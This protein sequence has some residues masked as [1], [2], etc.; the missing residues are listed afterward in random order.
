[1]QTLPAV[2]LDGPICLIL[3]LVFGYLALHGRVELFVG[4]DLV[5]DQWTRTVFFFGIPH[6]YVMGGF[7]LLAAGISL[8][9]NGGFRLS[10]LRHRWIIPWVLHWWAW[11]LL[12]F[13][14]FRSFGPNFIFFVSNVLLVVPLAL[15]F[16]GDLK[17]VRAFALAYLATT[18]V[19]G[20]LT[21]DF[22]LGTYPFS[23]LLFDPMLSFMPLIHSISSNPHFFAT[24]FVI[25]IMLA[26]MLAEEARSFWK[27]AAFF[28]ATVFCAYILI[29]LGLRQHIVGVTVALAIRN[30][31]HLPSAKKAKKMRVSL[32][33]LATVIISVVLAWQAY[34]S[35]PG[36]FLKSGAGEYTLVDVLYGL[37]GRPAVWK[38]DWETFLASPSWGTGFRHHPHNVF[39]GTLTGQG[40]V[41][42]VY[43]AG[44]LVFAARVALDTSRR[45]IGEE[46]VRW[47][48][49]M[50]LVALVALVTG[51]FSGDTNSL[52]HLFW[53]VVIAWNLQ[54]QSTAVGVDHRELSR[55]SI[56]R[57]ALLAPDTSPTTSTVRGR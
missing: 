17:R 25:S 20:V 45:P 23:Y 29:L 40:I 11:E 34:Q 32:I 55:R 35:M 10:G 9:Q 52:W 18:V 28:C 27:R 1:M 24:P 51:Q 7:I 4:I 46:T 8:L 33:M 12:L 50:L 42:F 53:P 21:M 3:F 19:N 36:R 44:Y 16:S 54:R 26:W 37:G 38:G 15:L 13:Y 22:V 41:G 14:Q 56:S 39:L 57:P 2:Y 5:L 48:Q 31:R 49:G 43:F 47:Q 30:L 6:I